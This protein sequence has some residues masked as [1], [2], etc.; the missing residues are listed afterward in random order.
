M[1]L[2]QRLLTQIHRHPDGR[3]ILSA[4]RKAMKDGW[5]IVHG[6]PFVVT[7]QDPL[8]PALK[9]CCCPL[10]ALTLKDGQDFYE[11]AEEVLGWEFER[12][13]AFAHGF[14]D[15]GRPAIDDESRGKHERELRLGRAVR[16][17]LEPGAFTGGR[18]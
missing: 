6:E 7:Y 13:W 1:T 5:D 4:A 10:G 11:A 8:D 12:A 17:W 18:S 3:R 15:G 2:R 14:D 16:L 9:G